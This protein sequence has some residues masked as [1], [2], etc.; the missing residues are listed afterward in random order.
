VPHVLTSSTCCIKGLHEPQSQVIHLDRNHLCYFLCGHGD[1][2]SLR[3]SYTSTSH[4]PALA[5]Q[6]LKHSSAASL[7]TS[8]MCTAAWPQNSRTQRRAFGT[9]YYRR[10]VRTAT[11]I[12]TRCS[13]G[14]RR[15]VVHAVVSCSKRRHIPG[16]TRSS[17]DRSGDGS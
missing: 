12:P 6:T 2:E 7:K 11:S 5:D 17:S 1:K 15:A 4:T 9:T 8:G 13:R 14:C 3:D 10:G 16:G